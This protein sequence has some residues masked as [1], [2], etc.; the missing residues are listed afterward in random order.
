MALILMNLHV[1]LDGDEAI[2]HRLFRDRQNPLDFLSDQAIINDYRLDRESIYE[3]CGLLQN[4]LIRTTKRNMALPV[5]L[6]AMIALRYYASGSYMSVIGD[7]HGV[8]KMTVS[9]AIRDVSLILSNHAR[10]YIKFPLTN[11]EQA[12]IKQD[13]FAIRAFPNVLGAVDG[14]LIPIHTPSEEEHLYVCRK[15]FHALNIQGI[16]DSNYR[17][18]NIVAK[19]PG[20][21]HDSHIWNNCGVCATFE[22]GQISNGYMLGDS[23]YGLR[24]WLMTPKL[25]PATPGD[26]RYNVAHRATRCVIERTFGIW[27]MR[28]RCL[29]KGITLSPE[30][31]VRVIMTTAVLHNI[32]IDKRLPCED[33]LPDDEDDNRNEDTLSNSQMDDSLPGVRGRESVIASVFTNID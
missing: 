18:L 7:A 33:L 8:S 23:G 27:K 4:N 25:A 32:C 6:Q 9:R 29:H 24:P 20:S 21:T 15:G 2:P 14:S 19:W 16:C 1:L 30:R 10:S 3:L 17:F 22:S 11:R 26:R 31:S 12:K 13:F 28:F 5:S